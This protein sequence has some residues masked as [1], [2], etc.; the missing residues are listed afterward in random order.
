MIK[1][2]FVVFALR[3]ASGLE[4]EIDEPVDNCG[5]MSASGG[6]IQGGLKTGAETF[7]WITSLF[8]KYHGA[9]LYAGSGSLISER[10]VLCAANSVAYE[11]YLGDSLDLNPDEVNIAKKI[12]CEHGNNYFVISWK[13]LE[14]HRTRPGCRFS[15][16][17]L[18]S[19]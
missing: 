14:L 8:T 15:H 12:R 3:F 19:L 7:P 18:K 10:H 11:N 6:L 1:L 13:L 17:W 5:I 4:N 16:T 9:S 2:I